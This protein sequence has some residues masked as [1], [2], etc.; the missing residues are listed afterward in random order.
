MGTVWTRPLAAAALALCALLGISA[1]QQ[2]EAREIVRV[3]FSAEPGTII[4]R[5]SERRLYLIKE[6]GM[7]IR[8]RVA[9]GRASEQWEGR[10]VVNGRHV[11]PAWSPPAVVR[12]A[13]PNLPD[14][15]PGGAPNNPMGEGALTLAGGEYA[16]HGTT[17]GMRRSVGTAASFGCFRMLNEDVVDL[18]NR[19]SV[20]TQVVVTR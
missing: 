10:T 20:G 19:V 2:A 1:P 11:R 12:R 4:I 8:Y 13:N 16:I 6:N 14:V 3:N 7:A 15:I 9:V 17:E 5:N 18:M